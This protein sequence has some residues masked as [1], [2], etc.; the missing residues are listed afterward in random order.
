MSRSL[1]DATSSSSPFWISLISHRTRCGSLAQQEQPSRV[2]AECPCPVARVLRSPDARWRWRCSWCLIINA[3]FSGHLLSVHHRPIPIRQGTSQCVVLISK[4]GL[5]G[6]QIAV[7]VL[8]LLSWDIFYR[9]F[10]LLD[11]KLQF[12]RWI[13]MKIRIVSQCPLNKC[14]NYTYYLEESYTLVYNRLHRMS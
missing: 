1:I 7:E 10:M 12:N 2:S 13:C 14:L 8:D 6:F 4:Y 3:L 11:G 5:F 9:F